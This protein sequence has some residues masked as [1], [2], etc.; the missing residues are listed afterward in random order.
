MAG[1]RK[2]V[3]RPGTAIGK[4]RRE[5]TINLG[6][7]ALAPGIISFGAQHCVILMM[8]M[9]ICHIKRSDQSKERRCLAGELLHCR[10]LGRPISIKNSV[11]TRRGIV[12]TTTS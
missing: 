9:G 7:F 11:M 4:D 1:L 10:L 8:E 5:A 6:K 2:V 3:L 12:S